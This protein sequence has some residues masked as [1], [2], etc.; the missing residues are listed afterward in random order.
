MAGSKL[1]DPLLQCDLGA[2]LPQEACLLILNE[3]R[4]VDIFYR[5]G[6]IERR[7]FLLQSV[8]LR[9]RTVFP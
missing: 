2:D 4:M 1:A 3:V 7:I 6:R 5:V 8:D 9:H